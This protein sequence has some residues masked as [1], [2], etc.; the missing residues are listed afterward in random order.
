MNSEQEKFWQGSFNKG[1]IE[2]NSHFDAVKG[3]KGWKK[4]LK[5]ATGVGS[6]LECGSNIGRNIAFLEKV[7]PEATKSIIEINPEAFKIAKENLNLKYAVNTSILDSNFPTEHFDLVFT[8]GVLI[9]IDPD[10]LLANARKIVSLSG[11]YILIGEYFNRTPV[12]LEYHGE[13]NKLFK[14]DFG[15]FFVENFMLEVVDYGFLWG[16]EYDAA[17]FDDMTYW[18]FKKK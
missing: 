12:M 9:H 17:G 8:C 7:L 13:A 18:L 16:F 4:M 2:R 15:K 3:V 10:Q 5:K 14:R 6:V 11:K 1:Y